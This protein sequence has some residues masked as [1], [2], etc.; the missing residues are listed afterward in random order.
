MKEKYSFDYLFSA[1]TPNVENLRRLVTLETVA[2]MTEEEEKQPE[3][4]CEAL[5]KSNN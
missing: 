5:K 1:D 4:F 2:F 3:S